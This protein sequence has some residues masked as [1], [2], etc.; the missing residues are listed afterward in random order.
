MVTK[1]RAANRDL[2]NGRPPSPAFHH[3]NPNLVGG[4]NDVLVFPNP[5]Y[6]PTHRQQRHV[7]Q[8]IP[9]NIMFQLRNPVLTIPARYH[10]VIRTTVPETAVYEHCNTRP[11]K[12][13]IWMNL[14]V[15]AL[16]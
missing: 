9:F 2:F 11:R 5:N 12:D 14:E 8:P 1:S 6:L 4:L 15:T 13:D 3:Q 7:N 16:D 10:M